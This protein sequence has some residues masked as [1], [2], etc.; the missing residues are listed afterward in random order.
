MASLGFEIPLSLEA[1]SNLAALE[2]VTLQEVIRTAVSSVINRFSGGL[3]SPGV[4]LS[5]A[6]KSTTTPVS[7]RSL[8]SAVRSARGAY[9][10]QD[11]DDLE[12]Q[13][14]PLSFRLSRQG[15]PRCS[16][17]QNSHIFCVRTPG[18][19][20]FQPVGG[21]RYPRSLMGRLDCLNSSWQHILPGLPVGFAAA[22]TTLQRTN[23]CNWLQGP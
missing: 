5:A 9:P 13:V 19:Q 15:L 1:L 7:F 16:T 2:G 3:K 22:R 18:F 4:S 8:L 12:V 10:A 20:L 23:A 6:G 21:C 11:A 14:F 17:L